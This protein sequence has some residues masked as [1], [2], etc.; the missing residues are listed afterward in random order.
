MFRRLSICCSL[1]LAVACSSTTTVITAAPPT[2]VAPSPSPSPP[3]PKAQQLVDSMSDHFIENFCEDAQRVGYLITKA[4]L[5]NSW[6]RTDVSAKAAWREL[7]SR[8]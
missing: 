7:I 5:E 3:T 4:M 8:C 1:L 2:S 6:T